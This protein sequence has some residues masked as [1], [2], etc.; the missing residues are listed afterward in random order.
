MVADLADWTTVGVSS[1]A[2][3]CDRRLAASTYA[4]LH[5]AQ[6]VGVRW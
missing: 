3:M 6:Q 2:G 4:V 1:M 5:P